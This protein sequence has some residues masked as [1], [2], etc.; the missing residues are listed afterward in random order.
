MITIIIAAAVGAG[1]L[2][3]ALHLWCCLRR[4]R[5]AQ[6]S[7]AAGAGVVLSKDRHATELHENP[8]YR[9]A[10]AVTGQP[11][12][13]H[14]YADV[15]ESSF[16]VESPNYEQPVTAGRPRAMDFATCRLGRVLGKGEFGEVYQASWA[17]ANVAL[18]L[19]QDTTNARQVAAIK[20]ERDISLRV[21][22]GHNNVVS[23]MGY[24][25]R[26]VFALALEFCGK[27]DLRSHLRAAHPV[28]SMLTRYMEQVCDAM[29]YISS[30]GIV[31][32]DLVGGGREARCSC[33]RAR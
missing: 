14:D 26:P 21:D 3:V 18:K 5:R 22:N 31:H 15:D 30:L 10:A 33:P 20:A 32:R 27:G 7:F 4:R 28:P 29:C 17:G 6:V 23:L 13:L 25:E 16:P 1:L 2:L 11:G 8:T 12:V 19:V 24:C 9:G